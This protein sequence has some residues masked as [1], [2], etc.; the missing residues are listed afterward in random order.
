MS[1]KHGQSKSSAYSCW[2]QMLQRCY[3]PNHKSYKDYGGRGIK[4]YRKWWKFKNFYKDMGNKPKNLTLERINTN[5]DY[6]PSNCRWATKQK[7]NQ[8]RRAKGYY[9]IERSQKWQAKIKTNKKS[10]SL[11]HFDYEED[12]QQA[13]LEAKKKYHEGAGAMY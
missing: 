5:G 3:N 6:R 7:Q 12:A 4:V 1:T 13:Y 11:G 10:I 8:N 9:W 2:N